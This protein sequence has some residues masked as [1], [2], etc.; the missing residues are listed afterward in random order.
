[1]KPL[2]PK[3]RRVY[4]WVFVALFFFSV[5]IAL[6]YAGGYRY[7]PGFGLV[8]TGGIFLSVPYSDATA[9]LNGKV[10][11]RSS[12]L[13]KNFYIDDLAPSAYVLHVVRASSTPW[14][15]TVVVEPK[16]VTEARATLVPEDIEVMRL[17]RGTTSSPTSRAVATR[18]YD[19]YREAFRTAATTTADIGS[20]SDVDI[21]VRKGDI[22]AVWTQSGK[23]PSDNFCESPSR[24]VQ[25]F[26]IEH[27]KQTAIS[28]GFF[29]SG[30]VYA[31]KEGG[32]FFSEIDVRPTPVTAPLYPYHDVD[33]RVVDGTLIVKNGNTL[34]E[35]GRF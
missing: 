1:M 30:V 26:S 5:P 2:S 8:E 14:Y 9:Y 33:M 18:L 10:V 7:K 13:N 32:V 11:G 25:E 27:G 21:V 16:I 35:I 4:V 15:K 29:G 31:T 12:I 34:Y 22:F 6:L 17:V 23:K 3:K 19:A 28:V 20:K 24:C